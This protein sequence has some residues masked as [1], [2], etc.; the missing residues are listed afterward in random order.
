V[1]RAVPAQGGRGARPKLQKFT[2][3]SAKQMQ[4]EQSSWGGKSPGN[5]TRYWAY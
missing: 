2:D 1:R 5:L 3:K 4:Q